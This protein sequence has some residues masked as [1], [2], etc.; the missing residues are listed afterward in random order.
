MSLECSALAEPFRLNFAA[1]YGRRSAD[2]NH[3]EA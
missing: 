2:D 1:N 3:T